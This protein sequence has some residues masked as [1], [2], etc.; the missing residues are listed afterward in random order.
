MSSDLQR[1]HY[2]SGQGRHLWVG[3]R[4]K[5]NSDKSGDQSTGWE[6]PCPHRSRKDPLPTCLVGNTLPWKLEEAS[7][8]SLFQ[9]QLGIELEKYLFIFLRFLAFSDTLGVSLLLYPE[10]HSLPCSW[11]MVPLVLCPWM[12]LLSSTHHTVAVLIW[13]QARHLPWPVGPAYLERWSDK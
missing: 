4:E 13:T 8:T 1:S 3:P 5:M 10:M 12:T 9:R 2:I 7:P 6:P 11:I